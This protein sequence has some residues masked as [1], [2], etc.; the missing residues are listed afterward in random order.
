MPELGSEYHVWMNINV[1]DSMVGVIDIKLYADVPITAENFKCLCTGEKGMS[2]YMDRPL[3]YK[4]SKIHRIIPGF[5]IQGGD[6]THKDG[7]GGQSIYGD[8]FNDENF[9]HKFDKP[10]ML[11]MAN[12]GSHS[13]SS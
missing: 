11:G 13:N 8:L 5:M 10:Y 3:H 6:I 2:T 1:Y 9:N 7:T 12:K 4:M